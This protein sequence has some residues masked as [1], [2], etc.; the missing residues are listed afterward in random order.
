ME[1]WVATSP[2][3]SQKTNPQFF[4]RSG[5]SQIDLGIKGPPCR[6]LPQLKGNSKSI[7][8]TSVKDSSSSVYELVAACPSPVSILSDNPFKYLLADTEPGQ[9][10]FA[11]YVMDSWERQKETGQYDD[12][13]KFAKQCR[14]WWTDLPTPYRR[15]YWAREQEFRRSVSQ[16]AQLSHPSLVQES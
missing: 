15:E 11:Y 1:I 4:K 8:A 6:K 9:V 16:S 7:A 5:S 10:A 14:K 3:N 2:I 13:D 12:Q